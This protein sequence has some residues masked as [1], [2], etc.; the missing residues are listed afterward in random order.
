M[1]AKL[2][3]TRRMLLVCAA[4]CV[5]VALVLALGVIQPVKEDVARGAT[6]EKA[7]MA[8]WLNIILNLLSALFLFFVAIKSK[9]RGWMST[10]ILIIVA[11]VVLLLGLALVDAATAYKGHGPQMQSASI[12]MFICAAADLLSGGLV[13]TT[14]CLRPK[15]T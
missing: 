8:F 15:K 2:L 5:I 14:T 4:V 9:G 3:F 12:I 13:V 6:P 7:V 11:L 10:S 1:N